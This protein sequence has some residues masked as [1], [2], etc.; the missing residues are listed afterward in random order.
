MIPMRT[1]R[2]RLALVA[3]LALVGTA[4]S[5]TPAAVAAPP[6]YSV[7]GIDVSNHQGNI[8]WSQVAA[9]GAKFSYAKASEGLNYTDSYFPTNNSGAK[10]NGLYAGAYS[11][12]RPDQGNPRG[13]AAKLLTDSGYVNDGR[14]LPPM[15]DIEW[16][17]FGGDACY[18]LSPS[19]M[20]TWIREFVDEIRTRT[21]REAMIYTNTNWWNQC[22]GSNGSFGANPLFIANYSSSPG[23]LPPGWSRWTLWQY[24]DEGSLPG[25]QDV[26]NGSLTRRAAHLVHRGHAHRAVRAD[27]HR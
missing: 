9:A 12:G 27:D 23:T 26:F 16:P 18:N 21:G 19:A 14:T 7:T 25:D 11:F 3:G 22:T 10:G 15:L 17:W 6:G 24:D 4:A 13:Q 2:F 8:N 1:K 5:I 20:V